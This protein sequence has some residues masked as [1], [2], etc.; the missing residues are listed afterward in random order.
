[1]ASGVPLTHSSGHARTIT[2]AGSDI[3]LTCCITRLS[4]TWVNGQVMSAY[5]SMVCIP[6]VSP[7]SDEDC[8]LDRSVDP[9]GT[10]DQLIFSIKE[11]C[12]L[13]STNR[14][15]AFARMSW[16]PLSVICQ[17]SKASTS[18]AVSKPVSHVTSLN[19]P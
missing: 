18:A 12:P 2:S 10:G 15:P 14:S 16:Y 13:F 11:V 1:M 4:P 7:T 6:Q 19:P 5:T 8:A 17:S 9:V 3:S